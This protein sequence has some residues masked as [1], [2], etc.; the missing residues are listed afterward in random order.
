MLR[1]S[2][3][4][5]ALMLVMAAYSG[6]LHSQEGKM[7]PHDEALTDASWAAFRARLLTAVEKRDRQFVLSVLDPGIR[8]GAAAP[9][10]IAEFRKQWE[11][12]SNSGVFWSLLPS[13]LS[14][15]S[16]Y[17]ERRNRPRELCAP[18]LL[19]KWPVS[20][21][22]SVYGAISARDTM[23]KAGPS[24]DT[25]TLTRLSYEIVR[26]TDWE[27]PDLDP[28]FKQNWVRIRLLKEGT[29]FVPEEQIRSPIEHSA[30]FIRTARGW[31]MTVFGPAGRD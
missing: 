22:P 17:L 2:A 6:P 3:R 16:A 30:C 23:V 31:R 9:R 24:W 5:V 15:G 25:D 4:L 13:A 14:V 29:G 28:G 12:D 21:D 27:V 11:L 1:F 20:V 26:V 8:N 19:G 7:E 10:G 18:Y